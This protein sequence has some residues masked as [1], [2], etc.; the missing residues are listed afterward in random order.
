MDAVPAR[1]ARERKAAPS[2]EDREL[3]RRAQLG[4]ATA[5]E[6]LVVAHGPAVHRYLVAQLRDDAE[7]L[8]VFQE[9]LA[10]AWRGLPGLRQPE[11]FRSWLAGIATNKV[12]DAIRRRRPR[13][14]D[15]SR[16]GRPRGSELLEAREALASLDPR[17]REVLL[18]RYLLGLSEEEVAAALDV[19]VGTVK[20]RT[21]R[22]RRALLE[23]DG[24]RRRRGDDPQRAE[25][26]IGGIADGIA[27]P[28][29]DELRR[30]AREAAVPREPQPRPAPGGRPWRPVRFRWALAVACL[31]LLAT[32][33]GFGVGRS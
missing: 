25:R 9:T 3:V 22:A 19:R 8:D 30:Y 14:T 29:D 31:L 10:A 28:A 32:G 7:A 26:L 16:G 24:M 6:Q 1:V 23:D 17:F 18:L 12:A 5:F 20:S 15:R 13:R 4:S 11:R 33:L 27:S 21:A 2:F